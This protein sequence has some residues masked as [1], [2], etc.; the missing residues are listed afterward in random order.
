[1]L[2]NPASPPEI[3]KAIVSVNTTK[4]QRTEAGRRVL[5]ALFNSK[6]HSATV[7]FL[8]TQ[9]GLVVN[10]H[11]GWF[12]NRV[13]EVL[14]IKADG[15]SVLACRTIDPDGRARLTLKPNVAAAIE[16]FQDSSSH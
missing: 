10:N 8:E 14:E 15:A 11:F 16:A 13:A 12:C 7:E 4:G 2:D 5:L 6:G 3:A 9:L 1:M